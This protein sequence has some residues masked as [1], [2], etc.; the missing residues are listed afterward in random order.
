M[1]CTFA[2]VSFS[3]AAG[4][5]DFVITINTTEV[6]STDK[7]FTL[8]L[9]SD[10]GY[11]YNFTVDR[12]DGQTEVVT[13][14]TNKT[15]TY[16]TWGM[17]TIRITENVAG[18]FPQIYF[19]TPVHSTD[20]NAKKLRFIDQWGT[21]KWK[22]FQGAFFGASNVVLKADDT[23]DL[24]QV[25][26]MINAF[27]NATR[28]VDNKDKIW[29]WDTSNIQHMRY[30]FF[31]A[32]HFNEDIWS[33]N[34]ENVLSMNS[35]F[36][37]ATAFN[38][39]ISNWETSKVTNMSEMFHQAN[40]FNQDLGRWNVRNVLTMNGMFWN[41]TNF[42]QSLNSRD[43]SQVTN[44][45]AMFRNATGF[46]QDISSWNVEKVTNM[47]EMFA[48]AS[49]FNQNLGAWKPKALTNATSFFDAATPISLENYDALLTGWATTIN[50]LQSNINFEAIGK[51]FCRG[52]TARDS[53]K[54]QKN[55][56]ITDGWNGCLYTW[57]F[58]LNGGTGTSSLTGF[59]GNPLT[60]PNPTKTGF[61][62]SGWNPS[63]PSTITSDQTF[64]AIWNAHVS[65]IPTTPIS[66]YSGGGG[67]R[68]W[69]SSSQATQNDNQKVNSQELHF[70]DDAIYN[71]SI[72][73][74][75]C[76]TRAKNIRIFDSKTLLTTEEFKKAM[77]FLASYS[78]T[79]FTTI[80]EFAPYRNLSRQEAAKIFS[81]FAMNVLC[82]KPDQNLK[83]NY[84]DIENADPTL[85]DFITLS[86][87]LGLMKGSGQGDGLFRP[88]EMISKAEVNAVLIRMIL[89]AYLPETE[90]TWFERYNQVSKDLKIITQGAGLQPV[91]RNDVALMLFR[92]YKQQAFSLQDLGYKSFVL[93]NRS[94]FL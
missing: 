22:S 59:Y 30:M 16:A 15:H 76:F 12:W 20:P 83:V 93:K 86:Y 63:L 19:N 34:T 67:S 35:M 25:T 78:M 46:N 13:T 43:V 70:P 60:V 48:G 10:A 29:T 4:T 36:D 61:V 41:A 94:T 91:A 81:Q 23:P 31:W 84:S 92:A 28:F 8:P 5:D 73:D 56:T 69:N 52:A 55:W 66:W 1:V 50:D 42:N 33:R 53:L 80:D 64:N 51:Q 7:S 9:R 3:F 82:R 71:P 62:F 72:E 2:L 11:T 89:K 18:G 45:A 47:S 54:T 65:P 87:Q 49:A 77:T 39:D 57:T 75:Y 24:S 90:I 21:I 6:S 26:S 44:M 88:Y 74:G 27:R 37:S 32:S 14:N 79:R 68:L 40:A 58:N 17:K 85:K 38:Q